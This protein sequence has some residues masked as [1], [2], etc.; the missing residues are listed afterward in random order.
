MQRFLPLLF[1]LLPLDT[2][3]DDRP[4]PV[5]IPDKRISGT[6]STETSQTITRSCE[7]L[8][9]SRKKSRVSFPQFPTQ[10]PTVPIDPPTPQ[11]V[12]ETIP[13][14]TARQWYI[15]QSDS[16][17][18]LLASPADRVVIQYEVG[19]L[20]IRG[21]FA[22]G[23]GQPETRTYASKFLAL[24]DAVENKQGRVELIAIPAGVTDAAS[25]TRRQIDIG[26]APTP[27][28]EPPVPTPLVDAFKIEVKAFTAT[29]NPPVTERT[30]VAGAFRQISLEIASGSITTREQLTRR[31]SDAIVEKIGLNAFIER[32]IPWRDDLTVVLKRQNLASVKDHEQP[33]TTVA[34]VLDGK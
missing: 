7:S 30:Q 34:D 1:L 8:N 23:T 19:P 12:T 4:I 17:F 18:F 11:D 25:I 21:V 27:P 9:H 33:W 22:D 10:L 3:A 5:P 20:R 15:V 26:R 14:L 13:V 2:L 28:D 29:R 6:V 16:E 31:T 32:W 24:V